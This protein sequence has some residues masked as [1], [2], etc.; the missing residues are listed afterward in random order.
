MEFKESRPIFMQIADD[1][2]ERILKGSFPDDGRIPSV[3]ETA[4]DFEVNPNTVVR[5]Y[6]YLQ[7]AGIIRNQR[8][9]GYFLTPDARDKTLSSRQAQFL[10]KELPQL[11]RTM[12]I[13]Q[14]SK[15]KLIR[16]Y[17]EYR[18]QNHEA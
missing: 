11:F 14:I 6:S 16:H 3:R 2:C 15:E 10:E 1:F 18:R 13:L 4:A 12:E 9:I 5:T 17:D 7:E 8:G